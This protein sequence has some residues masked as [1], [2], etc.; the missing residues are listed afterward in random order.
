MA[1]KKLNYDL[2]CHFW[3]FEVENDK[4]YEWI[5]N[6]RLFGTLEYE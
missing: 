4:F 3:G 1:S 6:V 2:K 5:V